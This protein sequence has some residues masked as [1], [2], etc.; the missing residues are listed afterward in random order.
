MKHFV[1]LTVIAT[2]VGCSSAPKDTYERRAYEEQ[3]RQVAAVEQAIDLAPKWMTE[4]PESANAV[5]ANG[6]A[7]SRD[8]SMAD[9]KAKLIAMG[10][11]CMAAGGKVSQQSKIFMQDSESHSTEISEMAIKSV[12]PSVDVTGTEVREIKRVAEGNRYRT[13][14]LLALPTGEA[15]RLQTRKDA[16]KQAVRAAVRSEEAFKEIDRAPQ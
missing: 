11:I 9:N 2:L 4:L 1:A 16:Q 7:V 13:Y 10:K 8:M 15:N 12:C 14:V 3:K 5:Y 6:S